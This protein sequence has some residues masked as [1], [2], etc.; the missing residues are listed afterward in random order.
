MAYIR[1]KIG[2]YLIAAWAAITLNFLIPRLMPGNPVDVLIARLVQQGGTVS[3]ATRRSL[4][5]L[6]GVDNSENIFK[7]YWGY[8]GN[9][10]HGNLGLSVTYFPQ[11]ATSVVK[12]TLPWTLALVG[13]ATVIAFVLGIVLGILTGWKR[14]SKLDAM[15]P[16]TT[17]LAAVPYFWLALVLVWAFGLSIPIFPVS[18]GYSYDTTVG[19]NWPFVV[20]AT[21]HAV[22]PALTIII[23]SVGGWLL[24]M[25]NMM[26][27]TGGED[28]VLTATAKGLSERRVMLTY[29]A[30]NAILPSL[31]G[32][33]ISLGFVV[34]GSIIAEAVFSYPGVGF[35]LL[36]AVN[37]ND[38]AL[39]QAIFLVITLAVLGANFLIDL[40][41]VLIDPR[42]RTT[43]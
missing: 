18:G 4:E 12:Q 36:Q 38:Y 11:S 8:L 39:M 35:T 17:F 19:F 37:N 29:A 2:F 31:A 40:L 30:R 14:G 7:Q 3:P 15:V 32:F 5:L 27:S 22:L 33:A 28:Y 42:T 26:V 23:S 16:A 43:G 34:S 25:R 20:S 41:Y 21:Y 10:A 9:L 1:N 24:G 13:V 6:L